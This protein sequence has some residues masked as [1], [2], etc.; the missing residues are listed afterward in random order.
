MRRLGWIRLSI[1]GCLSV[2]CLAGQVLG[3]DVLSGYLDRS[4]YTTET[5]AIVVSDRVDI[6]GGCILGGIKLCRSRGMPHA[7]R[8]IDQ[9]DDA[10]T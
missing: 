1:V 7:A 8:T 3:A 10:R 9:E 2:F 5:E 6:Q 4:Y